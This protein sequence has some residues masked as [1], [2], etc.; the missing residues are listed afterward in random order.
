MQEGR[1]FEDDYIWMTQEE[2][3]KPTQGGLH[4]VLLNCWWNVDAAG[5]VAFFN[6]IMGNGRRRRRG[7]L[8]SPQCNQSR[9]ITLKVGQTCAPHLFVDTVLIPVAIYKVDPRDYG[10]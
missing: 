10:D 4:E 2:I 3:Q 6:P 9:E 8:G 7:T 5:R 1:L